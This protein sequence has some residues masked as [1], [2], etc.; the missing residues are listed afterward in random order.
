MLQ[1]AWDN[2]GNN[3]ENIYHFVFAPVKCEGIIFFD[4]YVEAP[5]VRVPGMQG[6]LL[7]L[8][9]GV[10]QGHLQPNWEPG[11]WFWLLWA[12]D[13]LDVAITVCF[14]LLH[15]TGDR[16]SHTTTPLASPGTL[17]QLRPHLDPQPSLPEPVGAEP[18]CWVVAPGGCLACVIA[19]GGRGVLVITLYQWWPF[20]PFNTARV[21]WT[22][23]STAITAA[24]EILHCTLL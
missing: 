17:A 7:L 11:H 24:S 1:D 3:Q 8:L 19:V 6:L 16:A 9:R 15:A 12:R 5:V 13:A 20:V 22:S 23:H 2:R 14:H 18:V 21:G 10:V 4:K